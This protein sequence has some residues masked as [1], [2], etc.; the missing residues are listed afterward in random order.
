[1]A[2]IQHMHLLFD[3]KIKYMMYSNGENIIPGKDKLNYIIVK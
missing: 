1:M 3:L 2:Y